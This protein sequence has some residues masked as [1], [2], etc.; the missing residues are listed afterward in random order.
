MSWGWIIAWVVV[1]V[2]AASLSRIVA[3]LVWSFA[4]AAGVLLWLHWKADPTEAAAG[5]A[6]LGGGLAAIR[7]LRRLLTGGI[8]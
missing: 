8:V 2:T 7:P 6:I 5:F 4:L 1:L 3:R